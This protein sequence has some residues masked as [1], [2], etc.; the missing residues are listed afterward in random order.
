MSTNTPVVAAVAAPLPLPPPRVNVSANTPVV[1]TAVALNAN[2]SVNGGQQSDAVHLR[3]VTRSASRVNHGRRPKIHSNVTPQIQQQNEDKND[4]VFEV[5]PVVGASGGGGSRVRN[6]PVN[7]LHQRVLADGAGAG[8][9]SGS[10][11]GE[12]VTRRVTRSQ[13]LRQQVR[14]VLASASATAAHDTSSTTTN[15]R[16]RVADE[17]TATIHELETSTNTRSKKVKK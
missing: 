10:E 5:S 6:A 9:G 11:E 4:S 12:G 17:S 7:R 16:R 3:T 14:P 2:V 15:R 13:S 1:G 8:S